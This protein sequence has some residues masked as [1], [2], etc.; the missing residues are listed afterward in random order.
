MNKASHLRKVRMARK[1]RK[2]IEMSRKMVYLDKEGKP[3][4]ATYANIF[5]TEAWM[6]RKEHI[7]QRVARQ[8]GAAHARAL[9]RK[10][11]EINED[12]YL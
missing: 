6:L 3:T 10:G 7:R 9:A 5:D 2:P 11:V 8:Q 12:A 4:R 1:M